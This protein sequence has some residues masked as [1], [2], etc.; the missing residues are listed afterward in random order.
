MP[1]PKADPNALYVRE[2]RITPPDGQPI[3]D[4]KL[5][6][7]N[8]KL[9]IAAR[10]GGTP[11]CRLHYHLYIESFRSESWIKSW[12]YS[13]A[14]CHNGESGNTVFFSR[15]PHEHTIGY[16]VKHGDIAVRFG[17][18]ETFITEWLEKSDEYRRAKESAR[19]R[20]QRIS[21]AFTQD[22]LKKVVETVRTDA[23]LR[24]PGTV[25]SLILAH[26]QEAN[27]PYPTRTQVETL[28]VTVLHPYDDYLVRSFYLKSF[29]RY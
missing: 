10:E 19:K 7:E 28:V 9:V 11:D 1:R 12:I 25:L 8:F 29:E 23:S 3:T 2:L 13:I 21:K 17:C 20:T 14:H 24:N 27:K 16:V 22:V 5:T 15:K 4:W 18:E 26:Y 6:P